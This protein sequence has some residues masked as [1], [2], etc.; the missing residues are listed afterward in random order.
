MKQAERI[1][2]I[3]IIVLMI[4]GLFISFRFLNTTILLLTLILALLYFLFGFALLN[5][6]RLRT[7][8]KKEAYQGVST[9]RVLGAA[10]TGLILSLICIYSLF[11]YMRWPFA[12]EG[13]SISLIVLLPILMVVA[14]KWFSNRKTYYLNFAIRLVLIGIIGFTLFSIS[15]ETI[16]EMRHRDNPEYIKAEKEYMQ[17]PTNMELYEKTRDASKKEGKSN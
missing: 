5:N 17:D 2:G 9:L 13:L 4:I 1:I 8:F 6:I 11:K 7:I 15:S 16:L 10:G 12:N 3:L 14:I